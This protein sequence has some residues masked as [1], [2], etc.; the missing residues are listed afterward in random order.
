MRPRG[1]A[2]CG[3]VRRPGGSASRRSPVG[4]SSVRFSGSSITVGGRRADHGDRCCSG[5]GRAIPPRPCLASGG[6]RFELS[7][8]ETAP[9]GFRDLWYFAQPC[10]LRPGAR[11]NAR[12]FWWVPTPPPIALQIREVACPTESV[13]PR[14]VML[15]HD[16]H[17]RRRRDHG[18]AHSVVGIYATTARR[19]RHAC[20]HRRQIPA[21]IRQCS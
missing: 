17:A 8:D 9:N 3:C 14:V 19:S 5:S 18:T 13:D 11:L 15:E 20:S 7:R 2:G 21:Q 12:Q 10:V 1:R 16:V 6:E 4:P